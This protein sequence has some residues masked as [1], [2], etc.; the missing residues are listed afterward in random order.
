MLRPAAGTTAA[1]MRRPAAQPAFEFAAAPVPDLAAAPPVPAA[2]LPH[3]DLGTPHLA[4]PLPRA[5]RP[6]AAAPPIR[7]PARLG[8]APPHAAHRS[9]PLRCPDRLPIA[10][11]RRSSV[12]R[13]LDAA[14]RRPGSALRPR[15]AAPPRP[16]RGFAVRPV[17]ALAQAPRCR[18]RASLRRRAR[19]RQISCPCSPPLVRIDRGVYRRRWAGASR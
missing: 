13:L 17:R 4:A 19:S 9:L 12:A 15:A 7:V 5:A 3:P 16:L 14:P 11:L 2:A 8:F 10:G 1:A 6:H 18:R